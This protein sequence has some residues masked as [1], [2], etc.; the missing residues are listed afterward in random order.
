MTRLDLRAR[1]REAS[2]QPWMLPLTERR[3]YWQ[4]AIAGRPIPAPPLVKQR[5]VRRHQRPGIHLFVETGTQTGEMLAALAPRF[6]RLIS[7]ELHPGLAAA[8]RRRFDAD[9]RVEIL[10]GDSATVFRRVMAEVREPALCWLD[11][12]FTAGPSAG[13]GRPAPVL[14]EIEAVLES[15]VAG[16]IL[17]I[18]DARLFTGRG[19]FPTMEDVRRLCAKRGGTFEIADDIIRWHA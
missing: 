8:A 7:I 15:P 18:D 4:W 9:P 5:I 6:S 10:E 11:A 14:A 1:W 13:A 19:G 12:H 3:I 2:I 17:L 16:H